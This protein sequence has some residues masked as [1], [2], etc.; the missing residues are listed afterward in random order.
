[1]PNSQGHDD[2]E[3]IQYLLGALS[4]DDTER[5]DELSIADDQFAAHLDAA[6]HDLVD[7]Y[8]RGALSGDTL[9]RFEA[10]YLSSP[11]GRAKVA[12]ARAL[13]KYPTGSAAV[14]PVATVEGRT[15]A[16]RPLMRWGFA[17]AALVSLAAAGYL[18]AENGR[19]KRELLDV[20]TGL[21][22][23]QRQVEQQ[24]QQEQ[25][26]NADIRQ[27]L[28]RLRQ[29]LAQR[30]APASILA[31]FVLV[32][33]TRGVGEIPTLSIPRGAGAVSLQ[34]NLEADDF[35][36]YRVVLLDPAAGQIVW[37]SATLRAVA[38]DGAKALSIT[39]D[40]A[41]LQPRMYTAEVDGVRASG[42]AE[43]VGNYPFRIVLQ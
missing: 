40:A 9:R 38:R 26:A 13:R 39:L 35:P 14:A 4:E 29:S 32:P 3:L 1:M 11:A 6:E 22:G 36:T 21:D 18:L 20:R 34:I 24:L 10:H 17:A 16:M 7:A 31:T 37:R 5:L 33:P 23:R 25:A 2:R 19:L 41:L 42:A 27:E 30:Q 8:V 12:F 28:E 15:R 43:T